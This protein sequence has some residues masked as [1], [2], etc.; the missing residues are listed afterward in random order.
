[1][2]AVDEGALDLE[3]WDEEENLAEF[4]VPDGHTQWLRF[5]GGPLWRSAYLTQTA[6]HLPRSGGAGASVGT[7]EGAATCSVAISIGISE[8]IS[9]IELQSREQPVIKSV[10]F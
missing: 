8:G 5:F 2:A 6:P 10:T 4:G 3:V 9:I 1:M 7:S